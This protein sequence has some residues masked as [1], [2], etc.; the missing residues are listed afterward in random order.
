MG[1]NTKAILTGIFLSP[2]IFGGLK[3]IQCRDVRHGRG[4]CA[5]RNG[6]RYAGEWYRYDSNRQ[7]M[8]REVAILS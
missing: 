7:L 2:E 3:I 1:R 5:Y 8:T 4:A 6:S